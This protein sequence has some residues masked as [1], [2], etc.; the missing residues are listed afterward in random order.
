ML[1][2]PQRNSTRRSEK[3][4]LCSLEE[5]AWLLWV[6]LLGCWVDC[7]MWRRRGE[8]Q[9]LWRRRRGRN[10]D[11][12]LSVVHER[13]TGCGGFKGWIRRVCRPVIDLRQAQCFYAERRHQFRCR[14]RVQCAILPDIRRYFRTEH[15]GRHILHPPLSRTRSC[16]D[17][18]YA[19]GEYR[20]KR[21]SRSEHAGPGN[22]KRFRR[23]RERGEFGCE[24]SA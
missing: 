8:Q 13:Y 7:W 14:I 16:A 24:F 6:S 18:G 3:A 1:I 21:H 5:C 2:S 15:S 20:R 19:Y 17:D 22:H 11:P 4:R 10:C 9:Y 23:I 12:G